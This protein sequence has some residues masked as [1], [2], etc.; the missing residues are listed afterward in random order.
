FLLTYE[1]NLDLRIEEEVDPDFLSDAHSRTGPAESVTLVKARSNPREAQHKFIS[2]VISTRRGRRCLRFVGKRTNVNAR[3]R[4]STKVDESELC[5]IPVDGSFRMCIDYRELS[6]IDLYSGCHQMRMHKDEIPKTSFRMRYGLYEFMAMPFRVDQCTSDFHGRDVRTLIMKEAHATKYYVHP[7]V[8]DEHQRSSGLLLQPEIPDW[9][10]EKER[11][12][13]DNEAVARHR[14]HVSSI[15]DRDGMYIEVL[16]RDVEVVRNTSRYEACVRN[17]VVVGILTFCEA[18]IEES[19]MIGLELEQETTKV[20]VIKEMLKEAKDQLRDNTLSGSNNEDANEHIEKVLEIIDL[21]HILEVTQ[22]QI[23]LR[24]FP[25]SHT[26]AASRWLRNEPSGSIITWETLKNLGKVQ[27]AFNEM[28]QYYLT[29]IQE[30]ILFYKGLDVPTRQ[31]LDSNGAIPT[32]KA[33]DAKK[34]I[35]EMADHSQ[36]W[37]NETSTRARSTKTSDGLAAIQA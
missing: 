5:D 11:L 14:V 29:D 15:L 12:T 4:R 27:G 37:H 7:G 13:M 33:D 2:S 23:M 26:G 8:K 21:F 35:Q 18:E 25:M 3:S 31:I 17:M 24:V 28:P 9:K 19:K 16:E 6:K 36:K 20:V 30:V 22:D 34:A 1:Y 32:M 10:W